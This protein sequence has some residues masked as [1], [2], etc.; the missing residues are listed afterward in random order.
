MYDKHGIVL[1]IE[2]TTNDVSFFKHHRKVEHRQGPPTRE[3][4]PVKKTIYSLIDLREILLGCNRRYLAHLSALD[5]FSAGVRALDRLTRPRES[6]RAG[7][8]STTH[9]CAHR[10]SREARAAD[11]VVRGM[12]LPPKQQAL[13]LPPGG[14]ATAT[15]A[16]TRPAPAR[17]PGLAPAA[18]RPL[19]H[20][21]LMPYHRLIVAV[22][23]INARAALA[24]PRPRRLADRRRQRAVGARRP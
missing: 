13:A 9:R 10:H 20:P 11:G 15:E 2:T 24:P 7:A 18:R 16:L 6:R 23:L 12:R 14:A 21:R 22:L 3:L 4:A 8:A 17:L 1:R 5:D 19:K